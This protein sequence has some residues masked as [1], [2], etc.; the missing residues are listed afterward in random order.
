MRAL[1]SRRPHD[2]VIADGVYDHAGGV[3]A[4]AGHRIYAER[5][6]TRGKPHV[7]LRFGISFDAHAHFRVHGI[8]F[9]ITDR[10]RGA[11]DGDAFVGAIVN[12]FNTS[13]VG[14]VVTDCVVDGGLL[15]TQGL[16]LGCPRGAV[17]KRCVI[18]RCTDEGIRASDNQFGSSAEIAAISDIR[19]FQIFRPRRGESDGTAE[20]G[21]WVGHK[22]TQGVQRIAVHD[23]G[24]MGLWT[25]NACRRTTFSDLTL[26]NFSG[27]AADGSPASFGIYL[28][29][30]NG[31][32][33]DQ[34]AGNTFER[35][36]IGPA[37]D[38]GIVN[39]WD[40]GEAGQQASNGSVFRNGR[41][42]S[43]RVGIFLDQGTRDPAIDNV[44]FRGQ[45]DVAVVDC[46]NSPPATGPDS[47]S[48]RI[49]TLRVS[50]GTKR[51]RYGGHS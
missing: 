41:I 33:G 32:R 23:T 10:G 20:A 6:P 16:L 40:H 7:E 39:E 11:F 42:H 19:A 50:G 22:V 47:S 49:G 46:T 9:R 4:G 37:V 13:S 45:G 35:F 18:S 12:G 1:H 5:P 24:W 48:A 17:I 36:A 51:L 8:A 3:V 26:D 27:T 29:K 21:V 44:W 25:G 38:V 30:Y 28:E 34:G 43:R 31:V 14:G 15:L 2:I